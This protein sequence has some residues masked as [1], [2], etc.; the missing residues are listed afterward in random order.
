MRRSGAVLP[1]TTEA[2]QGISGHK[3]NRN[4]QNHAGDHLLQGRE[5]PSNCLLFEVTFTEQERKLRL[6]A[7]VFRVK[8]DIAASK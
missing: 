4:V 2:G 6:Q 3:W 8:V 1:G 7:C 5:N